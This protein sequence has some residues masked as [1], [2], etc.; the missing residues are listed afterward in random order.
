M[1]E[2][3]DQ[4]SEGKTSK[5]ESKQIEPERPEKLDKE[6]GEE[7]QTPGRETSFQL[8]ANETHLPI[9]IESRLLCQHPSLMRL[10]C[11]FS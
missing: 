8:A 2:K 6:H 5:Q 7:V 10:L 4:H 9:S 3:A 1:H 11:A